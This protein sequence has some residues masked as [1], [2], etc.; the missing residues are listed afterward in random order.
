[1]NIRTCGEE[2]SADW[3]AFVRNE[4]GGWHYHLFGWKNVIEDVYGH[5]CPFLMAF[6][7][8]AVTGVLPLAIVKS[9]LFGSSVTSLPFLDSAGVVGRDSGVRAALV[10]S[11][12]KIA[13]TEGSDYLE[14]RQLYEIPGSFR[15]D[16][17][18]ISLTLPVKE[19]VEEQWDD[20]PSERRNRVRKA[21]KAGLR[22]ELAGSEALSEF[23]SVWCQNMRDLGSPV[24]PKS[25]FHKVLE[26]FSE[27]AGVMIVRHEDR[28]VGAAIWLAFKDTI[29]VP[30]VSSL[31]SHFSLHSNDLLYWEAIKAAVE[32]RCTLF[33]F[34]RSSVNSGNATYK[35]RWGAQPASLYWHYQTVHGSQASL[36]SKEDLT[37]SLA[38]C[39]WK[40]M[41]VSL[42]NWIGPKVRRGIT[43]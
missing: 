43:S 32:R 11:A 39:I 37:M 27:S 42:A 25:W 1:M 12:Q 6:D 34:G 19:T 21:R 22:A 38:V 26:V 24:H 16:S 17:H 8:K 29:A 41:P 28:A 31:R 36:P 20:L 4:P 40:R 13:R 35:L 3:D 18:K 30:W 9:R 5:P 7:G 10:E 23:Y 14:L 2:H 33:D 15:V